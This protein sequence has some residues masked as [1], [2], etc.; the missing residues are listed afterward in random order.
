MSAR[1]LATRPEPSAAAQARQHPAVF[2]DYRLRATGR[3]FKS[4]PGMSSIAGRDTAR[5]VALRGD[6][7]GPVVGGQRHR[8]VSQTISG[9]IPAEPVNFRQKMD[10]AF[11]IH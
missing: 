10:I 11:R 8:R 1:D 7:A 9:R 2:G 3:G 6:A 4:R 5:S